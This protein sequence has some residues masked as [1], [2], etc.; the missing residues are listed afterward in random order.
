MFVRSLTHNSSPTNPAPFR[1]ANQAINFIE[2]AFVVSRSRD[3]AAWAPCNVVKSTPQPKP[4]CAIVPALAIVPGVSTLEAD[5]LAAL[6]GYSVRPAAKGRLINDFET[7]RPWAEFDALILCNRDLCL[8]AVPQ[9][10]CFDNF[11][12]AKLLHVLF[13]EELF[14]V[15]LHARDLYLLC[16]NATVCDLS[17]Q[18]RTRAVYA[19]TV[20]AAECIEILWRV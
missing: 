14:A 9:F 10:H 7:V 3:G 18:V 1:F 8:E 4:E 6:A 5:L 11:F 15:V 12:R 13:F 20:A 17:L 2:I 16:H 19:K